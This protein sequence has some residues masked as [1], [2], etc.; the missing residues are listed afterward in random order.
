MKFNTMRLTAMPEEIA[1]LTRKAWNELF[2]AYGFNTFH[3]IEGRGVLK[4]TLHMGRAEAEPMLQK[5]IDRGY[6][7]APAGLGTRRGS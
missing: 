4:A 2:D 3:P 1:T 7:T 6:A 5:L